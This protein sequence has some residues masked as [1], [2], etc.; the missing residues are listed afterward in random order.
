MRTAGL[1]SGFVFFAMIILPILRSFILS[2]EGL[3]ALWAQLGFRFRIDSECG[4]AINANTKVVPNDPKNL[5]P[6]ILD[7]IDRTNN[8]PFPTTE[9]DGICRISLMLLNW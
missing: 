9:W 5:V 6:K 7:G 4:S 2:S 1:L 3:I 8:F